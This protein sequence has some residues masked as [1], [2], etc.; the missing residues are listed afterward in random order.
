MV[1]TAPSPLFLYLS[2][3]DILPAR[4]IPVL[5]SVNHHPAI[6]ALVLLQI[7]GEDHFRFHYA[8]D[9]QQQY[10]LKC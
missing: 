7:E 4:Y 6:K 2:F 1:L 8:V 5:R 10:L 9:R 3:V